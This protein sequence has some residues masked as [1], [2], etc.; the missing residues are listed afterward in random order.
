M[1]TRPESISAFVAQLLAPLP[2]DVEQADD[3]KYLRVLRKDGAERWRH[4]MQQTTRAKHARLAHENSCSQ[5]A[6]GPYWDACDRQMRIPAPD[7]TALRWKHDHRK[8]RGG[9]PH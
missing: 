6:E 2:Q 5:E 4:Q 3:P 8:F 7:L 1:R 9:H